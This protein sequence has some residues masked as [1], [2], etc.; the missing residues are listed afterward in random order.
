MQVYFKEL[1]ALILKEVQL[2][3][4][5]KYAF[6]GLL[7]YAFSM[8]VIISLAL[9]QALNPIV[10]NVLFWLI[11]LFISINSVAKSFMGDSS[12][13]LIY[14]YG[15]A[16]PM[17]VI[18]AKII[19][20][21]AIL[22]LIST[23]TVFLFALLNQQTIHDPL[24]FLGLVLLGSSSLS[25]NLSLVAAISSKA[26]NKMTLLS[27]LSFPLVIPVLLSLI[28]LSRAAIEGL[29]KSLRSDD[30]FFLIGI[31]IGLIVVSLI[32]FPYVWKD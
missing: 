21:A 15:M 8:T 13:Q 27:V 20:N 10:W 9:T 16:G 29:D 19:Y 28:R 11:V 22:F 4:K 2:E 24:Y 30:L 32:L 18:S 31:N 23:L 5:Q 3:W 26:A 12:G 14:L 25:A 7:L 1:K 6:N 17:A